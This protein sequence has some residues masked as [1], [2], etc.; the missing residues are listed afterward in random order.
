[1][2]A[3]RMS[4]SRLRARMWVA[5]QLVDDDSCPYRPPGTFGSERCWP[6]LKAVALRH[7][8]LVLAAE[9]AGQRYLVEIEWWDGER[10]RFG[11]DVDGMVVPAEVG[12]EDLADQIA[13]RWG[14]PA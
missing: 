13:K 6:W 3:K 1:M 8:T 14:P 2:A 12:L 4:A 9:E 10:T 7:S 5:G 11:T